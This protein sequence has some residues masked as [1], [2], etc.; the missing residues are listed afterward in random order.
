MN[1]HTNP[2]IIDE[3]VRRLAADMGQI[4]ARGTFMNLYLNGKFKGY[5][6]PT[7]RIDSDFLN[8]W[9]GTESEWDIVAQFGEIRE[10]DV[11]MWNRRKSAM[12]KNLAVTSNYAEVERLLDVDNFIDYIMLNVYS[13]TGD[14]PH[15]NW[16]AARERVPGGKWKFIPWDAEWSFGNNGRNVTGNN[17]SSGPLAGDAD[18]ARFYRA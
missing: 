12:Q 3:L 17:L 16:R 2:F 14:W 8:S 18:I 6:N 1:D 9:H 15:N 7:E 5:Y 11:V 13:N 4:S 10:G